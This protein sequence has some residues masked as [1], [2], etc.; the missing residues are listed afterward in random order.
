MI[1]LQVQ[2]TKGMTC[3]CLPYIKY[4][5]LIFL[6]TVHLRQG[7]LQSHRGSGGCECLRAPGEHF[8]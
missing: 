2:G 6:F 1:A 3:G 4:V 8:L 7:R 5:C